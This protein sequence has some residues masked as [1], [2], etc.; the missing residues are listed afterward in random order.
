MI[1]R[2]PAYFTNIGKRLVKSPKFYVRD[3]GIL[4]HLLR[5]RNFNDLMGHPA[6]GHSWEGYVIE[7]IRRAT[8]GAWDM[9]YYRTQAGAECDVYAI[10]P[11]GTTICIEIKLSSSAA[12]TK[13]FWNAVEDLKPD[14]TWIVVPEGDAWPKSEK[15]WV[16]GLQVFLGRV[17]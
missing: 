12:V 14:E 11:D 8:K 3:S 5:L 16:A 9:Y 10:K 17:S 15:V 13:G 4:H 7:Q 6:V 2:L 1:N